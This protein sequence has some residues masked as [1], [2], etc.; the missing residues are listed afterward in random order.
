MDGA[1]KRHEDS[2]FG[3]DFSQGYTSLEKDEAPAPPKPKKQNF[4][5]RLAREARRPRNGSKKSNSA[6]RTNSAWMSCWKR[7]RSTA[8]AR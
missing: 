2:L 6:R 4:I 5:Q 8:K 7:S 3:Y 1:R